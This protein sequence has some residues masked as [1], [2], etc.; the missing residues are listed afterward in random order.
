[1][2]ENFVVRAPIYTYF[3]ENW[4]AAKKKWK[5]SIQLN[6]W[7]AVTLPIPSQN[8][9][10]GDKYAVCRL[11]YNYAEES[12]LFAVYAQFFCFKMLTYL[13]LSTFSTFIRASL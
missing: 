13:I 1:M 3:I 4:G 10:N 2:N 9:T 6:I 5:N 12:K 7:G 11:I 8:Y